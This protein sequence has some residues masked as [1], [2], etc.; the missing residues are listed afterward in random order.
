M[1]ILNILTLSDQ[2]NTK[3]S[4][5]RKLSTRKIVNLSNSIRVRVHAVR[6]AFTGPKGVTT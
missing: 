2:K 6:D 1:S 3:Q 4:E 5:A